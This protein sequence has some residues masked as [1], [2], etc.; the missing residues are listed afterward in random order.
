MESK[1]RSLLETYPN[2]G[3]VWKLFGLSL[4][5]QGKDGLQALQKAVELLPNDAEAHSNLGIV[6]KNLGQLDDAVSIFRRAIKLKPDFAEAHNGLGNAL[7]DLGQLENAVTSYREAL[8]LKPNFA[9]AHTNLGVVLQALGQLDAALVSCQRA[10]VIKPDFAEAHYNLGNIQ[11]ALGQFENAVASYR[12]AI[13]LKPDFADAYTNLGAVFQALGQSNSAVESCLLAVRIKPECA[14][15]H[16]NL[17]NVLKEL[18]RPN[19]AL[20]SFR[21]ALEIDPGFAEAHSSFGLV[22]K[23]LGHFDA[24]KASYQR[25]ID[26]NP[27]FAQAHNNLG[28]VLDALGQ[29]DAALLSYQRAIEIKPD[30]AEAHFNMAN[31][32]RD[33]GQFDDAEANYRKALVIKPD[34]AEA[35]GNLLFTLNYTG[36][37]PE[38]Y[39]EEALKYGRMIDKQVSSRFSVWQ[40]TISQERLRVG[41]VSGDFHKHSVGYFLEGLLAQID[42]A[43]IELIAYPTHHEED[44][45]TAR[46]KPYFSAWKPLVAVSDEAAAQLIHADGVHVLLDLSGY[47]RHNRLPVFAWKPAP[48]QVTWLGLPA[49]TG[50]AEM[51]YVLGDPHAIPT[52]YEDHFSEKVWCMPESYLCFTVPASHVK[53]GPLPVLSTGFV[54]FGSF[55]NLTKMNDAVVAVWA[56][57]LKSV[58]NSR[59]WLKTK[60]LS[61]PAVCDKTLQRFAAFGIPPERLLLS[62][63]SA[64][65][66]DHLDAYNNVDIA[67]DTFPYPGV[68]TS[69]EALW[70]GV[71]VLSLHGDRFLSRTADSIAH[72]A[73]LPDWIAADVDD[74]VAKAVAFSSNLES[75]AA[76]RAGLRQQVLASPLFDAPRFARNFE[77]ALWGMW[78][79]REKTLL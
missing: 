13:E 31:I 24:A 61:Q 51:D 34:F 70:M 54:A 52:E 11:K 37:S 75:L 42:P 74:Y 68:T 65:R 63:T 72:N 7:Q 28:V 8:K 62:K 73:G 71:P 46:I 39:L 20:A 17:G 16:Y 45:L 35:Q 43:R 27:N 22:L 78:Q 76:L 50:V 29:L 67:L 79:A 10:V 60:L 18:G 21:R 53:V 58:P 41:L 19:E 5:M 32:Q 2:S 9:Q 56:R 57:I 33:L 69:A 40:R 66:D 77:D 48:V 55:N 30:Y 64:S 15:A 38:Y 26:I 4:Q 49:T 36:R 47:T 1:G 25:A 44:E 6:L 12:R 3:I 23:G 14:E 59:L